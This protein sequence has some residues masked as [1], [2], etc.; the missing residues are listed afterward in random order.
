MEKE[1]GLSKKKNVI[2]KENSM[3]TTRGIE[4]WREGEEG[5]GGIRDEGRTFDS[6]W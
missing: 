1:V 5:K 3:V 4:G 2:G 6:E